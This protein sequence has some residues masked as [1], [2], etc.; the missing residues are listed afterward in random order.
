TAIKI[1]GGRGCHSSGCGDVE[2]SK[3]ARKQ[4]NGVYIRTP[5]NPAGIVPDSDR[6]E[7]VSYHTVFQEF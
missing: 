6:H 5:K 1:A 4:Y 3:H 2:S 7:I